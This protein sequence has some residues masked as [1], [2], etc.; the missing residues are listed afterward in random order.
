MYM[1]I[2]LVKT[3][4]TTPAPT[5]KPKTKPCNHLLSRQDRMI[6]LKTRAAKS[7]LVKEE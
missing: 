5:Q 4:K 3:Q 2:W 1:N 6:H 7:G